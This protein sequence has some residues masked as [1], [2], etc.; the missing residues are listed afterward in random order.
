MAG[1]LHKLENNEA[2]LLMYL[3]DE[4][5]EEDRQE[6]EQ[7]LAKD[8][9]FRAELARL[10]ELHDMVAG[11]MRELDNQDQ[12]R[13]E[14]SIRRVVRQMRRHQL[15][16]AAQPAPIPEEHRRRHWPWWSYPMAAAAAAIFILIGLWGIGVLGPAERPSIVIPT[17]QVDDNTMVVE[18]Q[19]SFGN[20]VV[21]PLDEADR[22][23]RALTSE[24]EEWTLPVM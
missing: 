10:S 2:I 1:L 16:L 21:T 12:D 19:R 6:V 18:L 5:P 11:A 14:Q 22:H 4:L 23:A 15:E 20:G 24:E 17:A 9:A 8:P 7:M 13:P 3:A